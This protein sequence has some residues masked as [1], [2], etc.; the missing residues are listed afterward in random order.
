MPAANRSRLLW[1]L[2][3]LAERRWQANRATGEE[4]QDEQHASHE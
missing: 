3:R 2:S 4:G 1:L